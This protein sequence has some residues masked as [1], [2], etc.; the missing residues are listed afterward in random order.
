MNRYFIYLVSSFGSFITYGSARSLLFDRNK[1]VL[2]WLIFGILAQYIHIRMHVHRIK[3]GVLGN[4]KNLVICT[5]SQLVFIFLYYL[6]RN[7]FAIKKASDF[8]FALIIF[9]IIVR[10]AV[11]SKNKFVYTK[12]L[13]YR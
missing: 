1:I 7:K 10:G 6:S 3:G 5:I 11:F 2:S 8:G 13:I 4:P 12:Q 9:T